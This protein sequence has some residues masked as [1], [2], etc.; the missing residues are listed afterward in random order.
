MIYIPRAIVRIPI[1]RGVARLLLTGYARLFRDRYMIERRMGLR[2]LL[3]QENAIDWECFIKGTWEPEQFTY[4]FKLATEQWLQPHGGAIF[5]DIGAHWGIYALEAHKRG[6]FE[7]IVAFE[8][9]PTNFAQ[10]EANLFLN[11]L[12]RAIETLRLAASDR[13][14]SFG[15]ALNT[16]RNRGGTRVVEMDGPHHAE[17]QGVRVDSLFDFA[18]KLLVIKIDV[19]GHEIEALAGLSGLLARNYCLVHVE[20]DE[21]ATP[22]RLDKIRHFLKQYRISYTKTMYSDHYFIS[23]RLSEVPG[24]AAPSSSALPQPGLLAAAPGAPRAP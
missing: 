17:C 22:G 5:L 16:H 11:G 23:D 21:E 4:F 20:S 19:E 7:R 15:L 13:D 1:L 2:L 12:E 9:D 6:L 18:G 24:S 10:L 14:R 8:P 3:D